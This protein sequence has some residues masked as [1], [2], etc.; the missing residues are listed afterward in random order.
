MSDDCD[1]PGCRYDVGCYRVREDPLKVF[2][3]RAPTR[4]EQA[5]RADVADDAGFWKWVEKTTRER[6]DMDT[7]DFG[8][9]IRQLKDGKRVARAGWNGKNMY[10]EL[11]RPDAHSKMTLPYIFMRTVQGDLVPWLASQTDMLSEDWELVQ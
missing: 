7:T 1:C 10:L 4:E 9:A 5:I 6:I 2:K 8:W 11:Q 3:F